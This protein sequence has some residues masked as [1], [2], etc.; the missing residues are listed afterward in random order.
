[1]S[2]VAHYEGQRYWG[3][4]GQ[5]QVDALL[6]HI[7]LE[8][9]HRATDLGCGRAEVLL[10]LVER[11]GVSATGIDQSAAALA[12]A[13]REATARGL[14]ER[15][16]LVEVDAADATIP[17]SELI[18][19]IGGPLL[20]APTD[21][22]TTESTLQ[23]LRAALRP[24]RHL[25]LGLGFWNAPPPNEYLE[26]TGL[27]ADALPSRAELDALLARQTPL[28]V[29]HVANSTAEDW[30]AFE[31]PILERWEARLAAEP[32]DA[33]RATVERKRRFTAAQQRWRDVMGFGLFLLTDSM[34]H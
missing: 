20:S 1:M 24:P 19:W 32:S 3:P 26:A 23:V 28:Q 8:P 30:A 34:G 7:A 5:S 22:G 21:E 9:T 14:R 31:L 13:E 33:L 2:D 18:V 16:Q 4:F 15:V 12:I 27:P 25:L 6:P 29:R 11:F 10:Q 17:P